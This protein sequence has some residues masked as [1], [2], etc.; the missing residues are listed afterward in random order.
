MRHLR[1]TELHAAF[2]AGT[3][4][5]S[6]VQWMERA[7]IAEGE[8]RAWRVKQAREHHREYL[9]YAREAGR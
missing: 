2:M 1:T 9:R 8:L 3:H 7:R 4:W 6:R 5:V